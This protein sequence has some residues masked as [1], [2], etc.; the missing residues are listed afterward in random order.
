MPTQRPSSPQ[1][2]R[3]SG[4][5]TGIVL[6]VSAVAVAVVVGIAAIGL[7]VDNS[8][9][10]PGA[11]QRIAPEP[12]PTI[13]QPPAGHTITSP[14]NTPPPA[15]TPSNLP[16]L[17][18]S[19][20]P[21]LPAKPQQFAKPPSKSLAQNAT[22]RATVKTNCGTIVMD[23]NGK[24]APQTVSS[25]IFLAQKKFFDDVPCHRLVP[26]GIFVLQ[27]GDPTGSGSGGPGYGYGIEN[28]PKDGQYP[29]GTV[30]MARTSDPNSNGSQFF[31]VY[32]DTTLPTEGGGYSIFGKVVKGLDIVQAVAAQGLAAD[33]TAPKQ[34]VSMLSV[35]VKKL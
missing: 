17:H 27:C 33:Q 26:S 2:P 4:A 7:L 25:F 23:L 24:V 22:W 19:K 1:P 16:A 18:C 10:S 13:T 3:S 14:V 5:N 35:T 11:V 20:P 15:T 21:A 29:T 30:A 32:Q 12:S 31:I 8:S 34:P 6:I 28:A 9:V